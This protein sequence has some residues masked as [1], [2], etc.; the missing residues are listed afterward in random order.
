MLLEIS[1]HP[2]TV[3][4]FREIRALILAALSAQLQMDLQLFGHQR[5][6]ERNNHHDSFQACFLASSSK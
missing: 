5:H 4:V 1:F 2:L 3:V 6:R